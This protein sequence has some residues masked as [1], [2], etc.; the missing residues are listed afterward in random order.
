M[1]SRECPQPEFIHEPDSGNNTDDQENPETKK[2]FINRT[3]DFFTGQEPSCTISVYNSKE[4]ILNKFNPLKLLN[5]ARILR[6]LC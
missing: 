6:K 2:V 5:V 1:P 3:F 4:Q